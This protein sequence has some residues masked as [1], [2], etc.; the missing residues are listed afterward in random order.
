MEESVALQAIKG[1]LLMANREKVFLYNASSARH[2]Y[3]R[4][5]GLRLIFS[6]GLDE[7]ITSFLNINRRVV[8]N[9]RKQVPLIAGDHEKHVVVSSGMDAWRCSRR[10]FK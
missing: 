9:G 1:Y 2:N 7:I 4:A 8:D 10:T 3:V 5:G 6:V